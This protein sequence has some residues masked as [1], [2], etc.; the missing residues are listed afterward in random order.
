MDSQSRDGRHLLVSGQ[1]SVGSGED[2]SPMFRLQRPLDHHRVVV[3]DGEFVVLS[4][5]LQSREWVIKLWEQ[6]QKHRALFWE[7]AHAELENFASIL[8]QPGW[9]FFE[10]YKFDRLIGL[11]YFTNVDKL[12][13]IQLHGVSFDRHLSDKVPVI[14]SVLW[15][16]FEN[17]A[18]E[19]VEVA[20]AHYYRAT[21][22]FVEKV[23]FVRE[24]VRRKALIHR[25]RWCD[26][27]IYSITREEV[28]LF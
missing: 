8:L 11:F 3:D 5:Q 19:R 15:W 9:L 25:G 13:G 17:F 21:M 4:M 27:H 24:G 28:C 16:L 22:R 20:L 10:V 6:L 26:E 7:P 12:V 23:G 14:R 18:V 2:L 1:E